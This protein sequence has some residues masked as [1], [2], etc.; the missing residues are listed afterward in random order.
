[1]W[2][3]LIFVPASGPI[4][5]SFLVGKSR[6]SPMRP[7]SIPRL[8]LQA[9]T[10]SL[11]MYR[12]LI[13]ELTYKISG[14]T[15][16]A[17]SHTTLQYIKN[18]SKRFQT[19]VANRVIE[20]RELTTPDQWRHCPGRM[21]PANEA[22]RGLKPQ[23]LSSQHRWWRGPEFLWEPEDR[24]PNAA[25]EEVSDDDPEVRAS[26]NVHRI[27]VE[28]H[29]GDVNSTITTNGDDAL[30]NVGRGLKELIGSCGSC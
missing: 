11:K 9:A 18:D 23:K 30:S 26:T 12:V 27:G 13:D 29:D 16:W 1:M 22:S 4:K 5:C 25:V 28:K 8:E 15:F 14:A 24:W 3:Y 21:N 2:S 10:L 7:I 19:Y 17:D 6:S 20:I